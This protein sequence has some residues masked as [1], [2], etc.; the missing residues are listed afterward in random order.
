MK[1]INL[2]ELEK[3][4]DNLRKVVN[5]HKVNM[6]MSTLYMKQLDKECGTP[7]CHAG[8]LGIAMEINKSDFRDIANEFARKIGLENR[9]DI[10]KSIIGEPHIW[11]NEY[12]NL[13]WVNESAFG[14]RTHVFEAKILVKWWRKVIKRI[15]LEVDIEGIET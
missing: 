5:G 3:I 14:L 13:M 12:A 9:N 11:G 1:Q 10:A 7:G 2:V 4:I 15:R 6:V 8:W